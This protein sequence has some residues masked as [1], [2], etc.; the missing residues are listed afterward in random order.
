ME[1]A[2]GTPG[3]GP[4][5]SPWRCFELCTSVSWLHSQVTVLSSSI[6]ERGTISAESSNRISTLLSDWVLPGLVPTSQTNHSGR[7]E[8]QTALSQTTQDLPLDS[9]TGAC[10]SCWG[11]AWQSCDQEAVTVSTWF[12]CEYGDKRWTRDTPPRLRAD[13]PN[14]STLVVCFDL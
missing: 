10:G 5:L 4:C 6:G 11:N 7:G 1:W 3:S 2:T 14:E 13:S 12:L 8:G 9:K